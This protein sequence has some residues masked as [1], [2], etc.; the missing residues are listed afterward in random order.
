M[1]YLNLFLC[2]SL[3]PP[4][5]RCQDRI[6]HAS[7][8]LG[9][10]PV[11][12]C[13]GSPK[14]LQVL[15]GYDAS[16]P[17]S[18]RERKGMLGGSILDCH[19]SEEVRQDQQGGLDSKLAIKGVSCLPEMGLSSCVLHWQG[20]ACARWGVGADAAVDFRAQGSGS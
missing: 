15:S 7:I 9:E 19:Q 11:R 6:Q 13:E 10:M 1:I 14:R 16:F 12:K 20:E 5:S 4:I 2:I 18:E 8:W 3:N 17:S